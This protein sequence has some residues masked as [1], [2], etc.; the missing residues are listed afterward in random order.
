[1]IDLY[2]YIAGYNNRN[3]IFIDSIEEAEKYGAKV[4]FGGEYTFDFSKSSYKNRFLT[5]VKMM[6][7]DIC[8]INCDSN[9]ERLKNDLYEAQG[10]IIFDNVDK[11]KN[12]DIFDYIIKN[13]II[14][15]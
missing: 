3:I 7:N 1:M 8:I 12:S 4:I 11:C 15:C 2:S 9:P 6:S 5:T 13:K 10:V 14:I